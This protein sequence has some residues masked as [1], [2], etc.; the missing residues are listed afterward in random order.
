MFMGQAVIH[1]R[2]DARKSYL[3]FGKADGGRIGMDEGGTQDDFNRIDGRTG[4]RSP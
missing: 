1:R 2:I 4:R 3:M